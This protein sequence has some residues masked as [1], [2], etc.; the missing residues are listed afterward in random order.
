M[1]PSPVQGFQAARL[2]ILEINIGEGEAGSV[3]DDERFIQAAKADKIRR[4]AVDG[5]TRDP[6]AAQPIAG[7]VSV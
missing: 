5:L 7:S 6:I 2:F 3:F 1:L 4:L